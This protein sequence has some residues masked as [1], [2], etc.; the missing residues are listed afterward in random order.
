MRKKRKY[1]CYDIFIIS[2]CCNRRVKV[3]SMDYFYNAIER[4]EQL[5]ETFGN[6]RVF[7]K[8]RIGYV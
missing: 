6:K 5:I 3:A 1:T 8:K 4:K 7:L 2:P